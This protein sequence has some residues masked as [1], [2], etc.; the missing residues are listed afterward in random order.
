MRKYFFA[1]LLNTILFSSQ[2]QNN[3]QNIFTTDVTNFWVAFDNIQTTTDSVKKIE[4]IKSLY[5]DKGTEGLKAFMKLRNITSELLVSVI[6]KYPK[7]WASVR[8]ATLALKEK[9]TTLEAN[10]AKFKKLYP[11]F[12][13]AKIYF[14]ISALRSGG[15]TMK[16]MVLI[17]SEMAVGNITTDVSEFT[18]K[19]YEN[20]F[21]T[22]KEDNIVQFVI[23]EYVH[24]QQ[25]GEGKTVLGQSICEGACDF[26]TELTLGV[27]LKL[28]Y[29]EYGRLHETE[30]KEQFK[31]EMFDTTFTNWMYNGSTTKTVGDLGY[32]M[33]YTI[34]K[35]YYKNAKN[36]KKAIKKIIE[37]EYYNLEAVKIFLRKS[38]Y[39]NI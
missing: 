39:Y 32:F 27:P 37:L 12:K 28:P 5:I 16:D 6:Q 18:N 10:I 26:I 31:K 4:F 7:F 29:L 1:L 23:H 22:Q 36:K 2:G 11:D 35:A 34:C 3:Q 21:K 14:T 33:G 38:K 19:R 20:F 17:G 30:L 15:T 25:K 13:E 9:E 24:T 8:P